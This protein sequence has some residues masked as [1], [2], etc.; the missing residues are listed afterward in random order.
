MHGTRQCRSPQPQ[1]LGPAPAQRHAPLLTSSGPTSALWG[2]DTTSCFHCTACTPQ[3]CVSTVLPAGSPTGPAHACHG[4][5]SRTA[6]LCPGPMPPGCSALSPPEPSPRHIRAQLLGPRKPEAPS[7]WLLGWNSSPGACSPA[8]LGARAPRHRAPSVGRAQPT[9]PT[10]PHCTYL[11][12][13]SPRG[14]GRP[15]S[16]RHRAH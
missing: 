2:P 13:L 8:S 1:Q 14:R 6:R 11:P 4:A 3:A 15:G 12:W 7:A 9:A 5:T 16:L 10:A